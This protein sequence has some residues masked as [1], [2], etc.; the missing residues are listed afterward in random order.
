MGTRQCVIIY[1]NGIKV[2]TIKVMA[3]CQAADMSILSGIASS[4]DKC[5]HQVIVCPSYSALLMAREK[6]GYLII[7]FVP[8]SLTTK[9]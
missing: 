6:D 8:E 5:W 1:I 7:K 4:W 3:N 2:L 9:I